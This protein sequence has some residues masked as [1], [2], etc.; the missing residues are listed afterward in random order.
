MWHLRRVHLES[1]GHPDARFDPLTVNLTDVEGEPTSSVLWLEN[2]GGKTSWLSLVFCTLRPALDDFLGRPDKYLGDY[3]LATD[4]SQVVLEF[5]QIAGVR[6]LSGSGTRLLL[7]QVLQWKQRRQERSRESTQLLRQLWAAVVPPSGGRLTFESVVRLMHTDDNQRRP[8]S[9][10]SAGISSMIEG[11]AFRPDN[12]Q[13]RWADWLRQHGLDPEVFADELKMSADEGSISE[14]FHFQNGDQLVQWAMPYIIPPEVPD[15]VSAVVEGVRDTLTQRPSLLAQQQFCRTVEGKL[16]HAASQQTQLEEERSEATGNWDAG[17]RLVDQFRAAVVLAEESVRL[18]QGRAGHF[19]EKAKKAQS[20]RNQRQQQGR[21]AQ[22]VAARLQHQEAAGIHEELTEQLEEAQARVDAWEVTDRLRSQGEAKSRLSQIDALLE[23]LDD[24]AAPLRMAVA[25]AESRLASKLTRLRAVEQE[26]LDGA[27]E[28]LADARQ[29]GA[30]AEDEEEKARSQHLQATGALVSAEERLRGLD[31]ELTRAIE[32]G[33]IRSGQPLDD[34][35]ASAAAECSRWGDEVER[36]ASAADGAL[37]A[38][39]KAEDERESARG[40]LSAAQAEYEKAAARSEAVDVA[41]NQLLETPGLAAVFEAAH[42]D[43]W[44]DGEAAA[45]RLRRDADRAAADR[46]AV[47]LAAATDTRAVDWLHRTGLLPPSPDVEAVLE[48]LAAAEDVGPVFSGWDVLRRRVPVDQQAAFI[49]RC[50][51]VVSG[52]VLDNPADLEAA[53][54][55]AGS[56][57]LTGPVVLTTAAALGGDRT[58]PFTVLQGPA[59][60]YDDNAAAA[61]ATLRETRLDAF[62]EDKQATRA[63]EDE[64][65]SA[66]AALTGLLERHPADAV[67]RW[68][69]AVADSQVIVEEVRERLRT[70]AEDYWQAR[71][72]AQAATEAVQPARDRLG[73][74]ERAQGALRRLSA[75]QAAR[76]GVLDELREARDQLATAKRRSQQADADRRSARA[77]E[78]AANGMI[79]DVRVRIRG[80]DS[81]FTH[82]RL[83]SVEAVP[84]DDP[85]DSLEHALEAAR[86]ELQLASPPSELLRERKDL[87]TQLAE[88]GALIRQANGEVVTL[89][90]ALLSGPEGATLESRE[91]ALRVAKERLMELGK[92]EA[93]A[94]RALSLARDDLRE[95]EAIPPS[96]RAPL[97][98]EPATADRARELLEQLTAQAAAAFEEHSEA[99]ES[100]AHHARVAAEAEVDRKAFERE[101]ADL[102]VVLRR[103]AVVMD[104]PAD[105]IDLPRE[106]PAWSGGPELAEKARRGRQTKLDDAAEYIRLAIQERDGALDDVRHL[107]NQFRKLLTDELPTLLPRLTEGTADQRGSYARQLTAQLHTFALTIENQLADVERHRRIVIEHL[108]GKVKETVKLLERMQRRTRMPAG[109]EEWSDRS[110]LHLTHP[111]LPETTDELSGKVATV[112]DRVCADPDKTVPSGMD[113]LYAA[114]SASI[115][116]PF[117]ATILKP[118]KRLTNERVDI[119]EMA[120][121]S[122][123][124][125]VT[126]ALVMF[127]ALTRMRTEARSSGLQTNAALPL[128]LDNPIGKANQATLME[129]QQRVADAFGL[130]LIYTTG[131]HDVGALASFKNIVRLDGRENP[132]SGH[133][134]LVVDEKAADLMYLDSIRLVQ[135]EEPAHD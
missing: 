34:A 121:F 55:I 98:E 6:T 29:A 101:A 13:G 35:L 1:V 48:V 11:D 72:T 71:S 111:K 25:Q 17:L 69:T 12:H 19:E 16:E 127:A 27:E 18:H 30:V 108:V 73:E 74:V 23:K 126:V 89:A 79:T 94:E 44:Q 117:H 103:C 109:L 2:M 77:R 124:Q 86:A 9:D 102:A 54:E 134:H 10:F 47:E 4:T 3:V 130:Q 40:A 85:V 36:L 128:L 96:R 41:L 83:E 115:G 8:L 113:L 20:I 56:V 62:D 87:Q 21:Q 95:K 80:V 132:R 33:L 68:R 112:V 105:I 119:G 122:G 118:H 46:V 53:A 28:E 100:Q 133:V 43:V 107:A 24:R 38:V 59:A 67:A 22:L 93:L 49:S 7:G 65:R 66:R 31:E 88:L 104:R 63:R 78:I 84:P 52:V 42:P 37:L 106:V 135:H 125:K 114:V 120:V 76:P 14:R 90:Q 51:E 32:D 129:V 60:L 82:W 116:G 26:T 99:T 61:E 92:Q 58:E 123:G 64:A 57:V 15:G 110:F 75:S 131:L 5:A 45:D 39:G 81:T 50:P 97:D 91:T 70:A